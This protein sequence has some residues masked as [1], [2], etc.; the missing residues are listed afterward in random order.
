MRR[1]AAL[2]LFIILALTACAGRAGDSPTPFPTVAASLTPAGDGPIVLTLTELAAAPGL[3][4][5][6]LIQVSGALRKQPVVV[7]DKQYFPSPASWG[8]AEGGILTLAGGSDQQVR[9]LLPDDLLMTVEGRWR[10]WQGIVGCG[11]NARQKEVWFLDVSR[12]LSPSPLTQVT[13]TPGGIG[14]GGDATAVAEL[15]PTFLPQTTEESTPAPTDLSTPE[16]PQAT[17]PAGG[18]PGVPAGPTVGG[19]GPTATLPLAQTPGTTAPSPAGTP[20]PAG[21]G[22]PSG[23]LTPTVTGTPPT[24]TPTGTGGAPGQIV[25]RG[26]LIQNLFE[27]FAAVQLAA[28]TVDSWTLTLYGDEQMFVHAI[29]PPP[30]DLILSVLQDGQTIINRQNNAP[31]GS[32]EIINAPSLPGEGEYE[33]RVTTANGQATEYAITVYTFAEF[34]ITFNGM[35]ASGNPHSGVLLPIDGI[36]YWF[37]TADAGDT[38]EVT[39]A[40]TDNGDPQILIYEPGAQELTSIDFGVEGQT[41]TDTITLSTTGM[42]AIRVTEAFYLQMTY[43]LSINLQ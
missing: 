11:K 14:G 33:V 2:F 32:T 12:I 36:H 21:T 1:I 28:G 27:E 9:L 13:L 43:N 7:C 29:A 42:Y 18:Y 38:L 39:V 16:L 8:L 34:P 20:T 6:S 5:D 15:S 23:T 22:T 24:P 10:Q 3:Y 30:A 4:K 19:T 31:A 35:I 25:E 37:F 40:P 17:E 41:E 26:D